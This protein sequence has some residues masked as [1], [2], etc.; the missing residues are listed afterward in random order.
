MFWKTLAVLSVTIV[1]FIVKFNILV[2]SFEY[3]LA[4]ILAEFKN[5]DT[6]QH[7]AQF[8]G[9]LSA[10]FTAPTPCQNFIIRVF[11]EY[12]SVFLYIFQLKILN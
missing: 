8:S 1:N 3:T 10:V 5:H 9:K 6:F 12:C 7:F 4:L 11:A 2:V